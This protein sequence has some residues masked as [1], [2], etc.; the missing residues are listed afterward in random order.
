MDLGGPE[1]DW[2]RKELHK[3][4]N[5]TPVLRAVEPQEIVVAGL[6][7][8]TIEET[9][10]AHKADF[11]V[12]GSHGRGGISKLALGSVAEK[13]IRLQHRPILVIGPRC[14]RKYAPVKSIVLAVDLPVTSLRAA[15]YATSITRQSGADLIVLHVAPSSDGEQQDGKN[16]QRDL[17]AI[18]P[19]DFAVAESVSFKVLHGDIAERILR[20]TNARRPG[21]VVLGAKCGPLLADHSPW[22]I[23]SKVIREAPWPVLT[24]AARVG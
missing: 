2:G 24:V 15:Q 5:G 7:A 19:H 11:L 12:M 18:I 23:L 14:T 3:L 10:E 20:A 13:V 16:L 21:I 9:A 1:L 8:P 22:A 6:I 17:E 4:T